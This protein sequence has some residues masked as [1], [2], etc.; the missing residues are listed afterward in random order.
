ML[1]MNQI[2]LGSVVS[3]ELYPSMLIASGFT[4]ARVEG[5]LGFDDANKYIDVMATHLQVLPTLPTDTPTNPKSYYYLKLKTINGQSTVVGIPWIKEATYQVVASTSMRFTIPNVGQSEE[6][7]IRAQLGAL[8][9]NLTDVEYI[10]AGENAP[11][12]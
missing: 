12:G 3:F 2:E 8:G 6:Q 4:R 9:F 10:N 5:I 1:N 11:G 7:I